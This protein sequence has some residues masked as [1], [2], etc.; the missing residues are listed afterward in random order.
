MPKQ[1][2]IKYIEIAIEIKKTLAKTKDY[3]FPLESERNLAK[4][5]GVSRDTIRKALDVL[6]KQSLINKKSRSG[7]FPLP[8]VINRDLYSINTIAEDIEPLHLDYN[9][10]IIR[11]TKQKY[12]PKELASICKDINFHKIERRIIIAN[13]PTVYEEHYIPSSIFPNFP[14]E[15]ASAIIPFIEKKLKLVIRD[16]HQDI[17]IKKPTD[18]VLKS[19]NIDYPMLLHITS[20]NY[21]SDGRIFQLTS[22]FFH[23]NYNFKIHLGRKNNI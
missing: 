11:I 4:K 16:S 13:I 2:N 21:L 6:H 5:F 1:K 17:S 14:K 12:L 9:I 20:H 3:D 7:H 19:L 8:P 18:K 10:D 23:P 22:Q 15:S